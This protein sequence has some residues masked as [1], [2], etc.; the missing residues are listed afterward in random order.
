MTTADNAPEEEILPEGQEAPPS[1]ESSGPETEADREREIQR[2]LTQQGREAAEARRQA[3]AAQAQLAAQNTQIGQL[4][5]AIQLLT[6]NASERDRRDAEQRQQQIEAE[7]ASL[8][9][10][11][12]LERKIELLQGQINTMR[13]AVPQAQPAQAASPPRQQPAQPAPE[14][15]TDDERAA[16]MERRVREIVQEATNEFGVSVNLDQVPDDDWNSEDTFY[17]SVMK[18]AAL[19]ARSNGGESMPRKEAAETP[20][21]M[22]D[23]IRQEERERLGV[24]SPAAPRATPAGR[25][26]Q[27]TE[28]DV[29]AQVQNYDSRLGPKANLK[30]LQELRQGM[31]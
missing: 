29:R 28:A 24:S 9:P 21:Q 8:P 22:R 20:A 25:K 10:A 16:Y 13:T 3:A 5:T 2:R 23:R 31:G 18:Q 14:Q 1:P 7:L 26:K 11:D 19:A 4:Q 6:A 27:A 12:R 15:G 17:R 30:R